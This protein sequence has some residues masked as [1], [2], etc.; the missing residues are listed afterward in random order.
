MYKILYNICNIIH[1]DIIR[2]IRLMINYIYIFFFYTTIVDSDTCKNNSF[3][4]LNN[5]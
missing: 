2:K 3:V 5:K 4:Y 1:F